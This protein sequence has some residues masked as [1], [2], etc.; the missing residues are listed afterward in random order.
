MYVFLQKLNIMW[1]CKNY[2]KE[3][4]ISESITESSLHIWTPNYFRVFSIL[5]SSIFTTQNEEN[6][7]SYFSDTDERRVWIASSEFALIRISIPS[8]RCAK[9]HFFRS[10]FCDSF[11]YMSIMFVFCLKYEELYVLQSIEFFVGVL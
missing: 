3:F 4:F 2:H 7:L 6:P 9:L 11:E 5:K 8:F 10:S 1:S